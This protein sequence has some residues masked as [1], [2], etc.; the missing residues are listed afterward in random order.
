MELQ[1][2]KS[3]DKT[4]QLSSQHLPLILAAQKHVLSRVQ[5]QMLVA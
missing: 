4:V 3:A 1:S 5:Y 2:R